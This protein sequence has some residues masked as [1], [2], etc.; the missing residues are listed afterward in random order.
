MA[1]SLEDRCSTLTLLAVAS[2]RSMT[3]L[4]IGL[5]LIELAVL[6]RVMLRPHPDASRQISMSAFN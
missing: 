2:D 6:A 4:Y 1:T 3:F 5:L